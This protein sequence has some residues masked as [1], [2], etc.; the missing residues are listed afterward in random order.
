MSEP[1][2]TPGWI[3]SSTHPD[4]EVWF[5]GQ[6]ETTL[7]RRIDSSA[8]TAVAPVAAPVPPPAAAAV[9]P[10]AAGA[11][12]A[13]GFDRAPGIPAPPAAVGL[14][15]AVEPPPPEDSGN[16]KRLI[17][18][19]AVA[20]AL[21]IGGVVTG[22]V[23]AAGG[24]DSAGDN[25]AAGADKTQADNSGS[26]SNSDD[27]SEED[28][29]DATTS[30][31]TSKLTTST[32]AKKSTASKGPSGASAVTTKATTPQTPPPT[33]MT[34]ATAPVQIQT[35][36]STT[37]GAGSTPWEGPITAF[38]AADNRGDA[39]AVADQYS[40]PLPYVDGDPM[41]RDELIA[42]LYEGWST[43]SSHT[44][45]LSSPIT[46]QSGPTPVAG[47]QEV[48]VGYRFTTRWVSSDP[49][50]DTPSGCLELSAT[51]RVRYGSGA[52]ITSHLTEPIGSC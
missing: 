31:V 11:A 32:S 27:T 16:K 6:K 28:A 41:S 22:A 23:L 48:T 47:G 51:D 18:I 13:A 50:S 19:L 30:A 37:L 12:A 38:I 34:V 9:P 14:G 5:D 21:L 17:V 46:V 43:Q 26:G 44:L 49:T 10:P 3:P 15:V 40:Y 45:A 25:T 35:L 33:P 24:D 52:T 4:Q 36:P 29:S 8:D 39:N 20:A 1:T 2:N 42:D 7:T